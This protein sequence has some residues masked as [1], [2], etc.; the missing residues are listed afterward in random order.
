MADGT[1]GKSYLAGLS[2]TYLAAL[3]RMVEL[4]KLTGDKEKIALFTHRQDI[5]RQSLPQLLTPS[6]YFVKSLEQG[7]VMHGV[8]GQKKYGYLEGVTN[9]DAVGLRVSDDK[10]S[11]GIYKQIASFPQ[12]RP[13]DF[14]LTNAPGL[15]DT[16]MSWG[17]TD[18]KEMGGIY[19]YGCWVNGGVWGTVEGRAILMYS[20]LGKFEDIYKS[21]IRN[22]KWSKDFRM[23]AP[24]T[25]WGENF[26]NDW[27]EKGQWLHGEGVAVMVDNMAIPAATIRGLFDYEYK[28]DRLLL[29]PRI[30]GSITQ[31]T[32]KEPVRFGDK[33]LYISCRNGGPKVNSVTVNGKPVKVES[34]DAVVLKY[35]ELPA[36]A[37]VEIVTGGGWPKEEFTADYPAIPRLVNEK[38]VKGSFPDSLQ[39]RYTVLGKTDQLLAGE[40]GAEYDRT[41]ITAALESFDAFR[42]RAGM[43]PG[44]GYYRPVDQQ[45]KEAMIRLYAKT[46]MGMYRGVEKRMED[47][48][49]KGDQIQKRISTLF[50]KV[51]ND[52]IKSK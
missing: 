16:Y 36:D 19:K 12:I 45:R 30:P 28:S 8:V 17:N 11:Q 7:G 46:A 32:Q 47:Y 3:D 41:F 24:F 52:R 10:T 20:R 29:R 25:Q 4:Y 31:F 26:H 15:D 21:G 23:D 22:M 13:F 48:S 6:G 5:T 27:Y 34:A 18:G 51:N 14:L 38:S 33:K 43:E 9:A 37:K 50:F 35:K 40:K 1:F 42:V 39:V 2:V 49:K 44:Q